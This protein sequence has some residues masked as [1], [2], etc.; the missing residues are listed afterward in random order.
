MKII[1]FTRCFILH[2]C[3][4]AGQL[5]HA[6]FTRGYPQVLVRTCTQIVTHTSQLS[7]TLANQDGSH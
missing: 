3:E 6:L 7:F 2:W 4:P 5:F 1:D